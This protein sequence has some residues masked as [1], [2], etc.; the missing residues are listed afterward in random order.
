MPPKKSD[1]TL[2]IVESP[3]KIKKIQ[4][5]LGDS[6]IVA[7]SVGHII[8]LSAK[9]MSIDIDNDFRPKYEYLP[10]KEKVIND[11]KRLAKLS[12]DILLA[13]D[14]DREG[15]MIAWSL[16]HVLEIKDPKRITFNS[17]TAEEILNA[18]KKPHKIDF[19]M[20]DA[21]KARRILDRIVGYEISPILWKSIGQAL[22]A[23]RVQSV[24]VKLIID[25]ETEIDEFFNSKLKSFFNVTGKF[26][27]KKKVPFTSVLFSTKKSKVQEIDTEEDIEDVKDLASET[28][29]AKNGDLKQGNKF[30]LED[31]K[32]VK[33]VLKSLQKS[34]FKIQGIGS[35]E[36]LRNPA[37]PFTTSTLQQEASRKLGFAIKRTM[38][39]AQNLYEAGHITYMRTDSV[40]LSKD[41]MKTITK[42]VLDKY[43]KSYSRPKEYKGKTSNSQEAHEA[44]RPTHVEHPEVNQKGKVGSD[45]AKLYQLIWKRSVSSQMSPAVF[46][47]NTTQIGISEL[48]DNFFSTEVS[49]VKFNGFLAVYD[50]K[51]LENE[52]PEKNDDLVS[53]TLPKV[54]EEIKYVNFT[55]IQNFQRPPP[56]Y[57][58]AMLVK[59]LDPDNLNIGR[60]ST[61]AAITTKIQE[62]EYVKKMDHEGKTVD[63]V[64]LVCDSKEIKE[65]KHQVTLGKDMNR[66]SPTHMG[67]IV[68]KFLIDYFPD[69]MDYKFT[70]LMET[71]L[72]KIAEGK[73][74]LTKVLGGFYK[75]FH[76]IVSSLD[77]NSIKIMDE[78]KR[79]IGKDPESGSNVVATLRK[80]GPVVFIETGKTKENIAPIKSPLSLETI[81][82]KQ[83]LELLSYPKIL[84]KYEKK[85]VKLHRGKFGLYVKYGEEN[86]SLNKL[87]L[88][89]EG[90][91]KFDVVVE[92]IKDKLKKYLW[93]GKEG[94]V[95]YLIMEG[96]YGKYINIADKSK[97]TN[98]PLNIR[99]AEGVKIEELTLDKVKELVEE[100]KQHKFKRKGTPKPES[101]VKKE[102]DTNKEPVKKEPVKK[103][104]V[105]RASRTSTKK[106]PTKKTPTKRKT[107]KK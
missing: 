30:L 9:K 57:N 7:A 16:A 69:I 62:K 8:D 28:E 73:S 43:G 94:K 66:L 21:Q 2:V 72:D 51:N 42:Y 41:A 63:Y 89:D 10:G 14:E 91:L 74:D 31:I 44:V 5:I 32:E 38:S 34:K 92:L 88:K 18:V 47:I 90:E 4:D 59:K 71:N 87:E 11:L 49:T 103:E 24:V 56:R 3:G 107:T 36:S 70:A 96:P 104:P 67:K 99:L 65:E 50:I 23:G 77:K 22:S 86:I 83:A 35:R 40:N 82:L 78:S 98:K 37:P 17:I 26:L 46:N 54:G 29:T 76:K 15:E 58:E 68:T 101:G 25:R 105:K 81:T 45:E 106:T 95:E 6:Y 48:R 1:K 100:G 84:G 79:I 39:A 61:Y 19:D 33:Q 20:V 85:D 60:P 102:E 12:S 52:N 93:S 75:D 80:Y 97:K 13:T 55:S 64:T 27:D 53:I